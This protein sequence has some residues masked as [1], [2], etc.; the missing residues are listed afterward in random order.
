MRNY[1]LICSDLSG[2][3]HTLA[4]DRF[5]MVDIC[6]YEQYIL[7]AR[8]YHQYVVVVEMYIRT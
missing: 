1:T 5:T 7:K 3:D 8:M 4:V 2:N 6:V